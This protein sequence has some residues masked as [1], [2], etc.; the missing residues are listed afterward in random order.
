MG[1]RDSNGR[2]KKGNKLNSTFSKGYNKKSWF[3]KE[4]K[5][6]KNKGRLGLGPNKTSFKKGVSS[7]NKGK[8]LIHSGSFKSGKE[9]LNWQGGIA[10][11]PYPYEFNKQ[12]KSTIRKRDNYTC[13]ICF[14]KQSLRTFVI[15]HIDYNKNNNNP[16]NLITLC[17]SCHAKTNFNRDAWI[18]FFEG[19]NNGKI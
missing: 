14:K 10:H 4:H 1:N 13:K 2:F 16:K 15:H 8:S 3:K 6:I 12:L 18:R 5:G 9:H 19:V 17:R 11:L 7:W